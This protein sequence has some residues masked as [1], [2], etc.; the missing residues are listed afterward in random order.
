MGVGQAE[1]D[2]EIP[3]VILPIV[4]EKVTNLIT[5]LSKCCPSPTSNSVHST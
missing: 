3:L 2:V 1:T 4:T 5:N